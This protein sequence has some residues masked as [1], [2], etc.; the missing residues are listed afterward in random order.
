ML[1]AGAADGVLLADCAGPVKPKLNFAEPVL[2]EVTG[3]LA[4]ALLA[5]AA[6]AGTL[7]WANADCR[8]EPLAVVALG[9]VNENLSGEPVFVGPAAFW[10][11]CC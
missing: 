8:V 6:D 7:G 2:E 11:V 3:V 10:F 1:E 9:C 5:G 4:E